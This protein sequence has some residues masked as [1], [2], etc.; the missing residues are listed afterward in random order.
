MAPIT[1]TN[2]NGWGTATQNTLNTSH[3]IRHIRNE[4]RTHNNRGKVNILCGPGLAAPGQ[5][6]VHHPNCLFVVSV[7]FSVYCKMFE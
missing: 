3:T 5:L 2:G 1:T 4:I 6:F 7:Y